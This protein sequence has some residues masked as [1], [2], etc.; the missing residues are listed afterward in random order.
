[1]N[2]RINGIGGSSGVVQA[3][4]VSGSFSAYTTVLTNAAGLFNGNTN[5][6]GITFT[7][8]TWTNISGTGGGSY[9]LS[10]GGDM[11]TAHV[12]DNTNSRIYRVTA[13]H[14]A[15]TTGGYIAIERMA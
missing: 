15:G 9:T 6:G 5:A 3:S 14:C 11:L 13:I 8:G 12:I 1:M 7:A 10:S 4:A 2:V